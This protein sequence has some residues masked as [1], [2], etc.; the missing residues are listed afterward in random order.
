MGGLHHCLSSQEAWL[1][2]TLHNP[3]RNHACQHCVLSHTTPA[4]QHKS[5]PHLNMSTDQQ[6]NAHTVQ[7]PR[8]PPMQQLILAHP[9]RGASNSLSPFSE[10]SDSAVVG[11]TWVVRLNKYFRA[12]KETDSKNKSSLLLHYAGEEMFKQ[13]CSLPHMG[14]DNDYDK[15]FTDLNE[16]FNPQMNPDFVKFKLRQAQQGEG[17]PLTSSKPTY[18][19]LPALALTM[20]HRSWW[21]AQIIES[22]VEGRL[23]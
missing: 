17:N 19:N 15:A 1:P 11:P 21:K 5:P 23:P 14:A 18:M 2:G 7:D 3:R 9:I 12:P 10:L 4:L 22:S 8:G 16:Y 13:F 6:E 20:I